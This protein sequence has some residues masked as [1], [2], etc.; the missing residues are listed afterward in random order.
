[1]KKT[2]GRAFVL[3]IAVALLL[4]CLPTEAPADAQQGYYSSVDTTSAATLRPTLHDLID[5]HTRFPYTSSATDTWDILELADED[6]NNSDNIIDVYKNATFTKQGGGNSFYQ[7]EHTWP[8]SYGFPDDNSQNYPYTDCHHL[9]LCFGG[10]NA[11]RS[12]KPYRYCDATCIEKPTDFNNG[13]GGGSGT[14]SGNSSWTQGSYTYGTWETWIGRRGDVA[15]ALFYMDVRYEG[16]MHSIS[17]ASEPDLILTDNV[18]LIANSNTEQNEV[19]AYMGMKSVLLQWHVE[20]PVDALEQARNDVIFSYQENRNPFIDHPEWVDCIFSNTNCGGD[21]DPPVITSCPSWVHLGAEN[22]S[23]LPLSSAAWITFVNLILVTDNVDPNPTLTHNAPNPLPIGETTVTF[24]ATD[25]SNNDS[26][27]LVN[28]RIFRPADIELVLDDTGSMNQSTGDGTGNSKIQSLRN[29]VKMFTA[30]LSQFRTGLGD[31]IGAI[32]FKVPPGGN[33]MS[34]CPPGWHQELV[35]L[36]ALDSMLTTIDSTVDTMPADG[37][38][39]PIRTGIEVA[40]NLLE[41]QPGWRRRLLLLL[42]DGMQNTDNCMIGP[43]A[44]GIAQF[45]QTQITDRD[46]QLL[47]VGF[48]AASLIDADLLDE[49]ASSP[50]GFYDTA[51]SSQDLNKWFAQALSVILEQAVVIDPQGS[52]APGTTDTISVQLT[53]QARSVT[54]L[55]AWARDQAEMNLTFQTPGP[56][57]VTVD[58]SDY[59]EPHD[60]IMALAGPTYR[61]LIM[62]FALQGELEGKHGGIWNALV[63]RAKTDAGPDEPYI[64]MVLA[65]S[66]LKMKPIIPSVDLT[67]GGRLPLLVDLG[68]MKVAETEVT[69]Q[70]FVP[71]Q[72]LGTQLANM[73]LTDNEVEAKTVDLGHDY[74]LLARRIALLQQLQSPEAAIDV[75]TLALYDDGMHNDIGANDGVFGN[76][77]GPLPV[78]GAYAVLYCAVGTTAAGE[79]FHREFRQGLYIPPKLSPTESKVHV[80]P[81][82]AEGRV[83]SVAVIPRDVNGLLL[84]PGHA[85]S[86]LIDVDDASVSP[87]TDN[88]DGSYVVVVTLD[89]NTD[90]A[91]LDVAVSGNVIHSMVLGSSGTGG[92]QWK[93]I[94][95]IIV[96]LTMVLVL[97]V[98]RFGRREHHTTNR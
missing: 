85:N 44:A 88:G 1:M 58:S 69:A 42:S 33:E 70:V 49:L 94:A 74:N 31:M 84:G 80:T 47:A 48:G 17:G 78:D 25:A 37:W 65:D 50:N 71:K 5:D 76:T 98:L 54:F 39:T 7:R 57:P 38:G 6:P 34:A 82:Q 32:A 9:F 72:G 3:I 46:I 77:F 79:P 90:T 59:L 75:H 61:A 81:R 87:I 16:G 89:K 11:S 52:I 93:W 56:D 14:Y 8:K 22:S 41:S 62:R 63:S 12:N 24:T 35:P 43:D 68:G 15:R 96:A 30:I 36:S 29:S 83:F 51:Q 92:I 18:T 40:S 60:G 28:V 67:T 13:Q 55:L 64:L 66:P 2:I 97:A 4:L 26:N 73:K 23:G 53:S 21:I 20:D 10:Y 86:I 27:C 91:Q 19:V 95:A 45:K